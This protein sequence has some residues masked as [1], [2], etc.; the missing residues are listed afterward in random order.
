LPFG[1]HRS[2]AEVIECEEIEARRA[3]RGQWKAN[4]GEWSRYHHLMSRAPLPPDDAA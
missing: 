4:S 1:E 2:M 3:L